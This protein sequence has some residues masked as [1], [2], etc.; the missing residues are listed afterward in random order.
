MNLEVKQLEKKGNLLKLLIKGATPELMNS[1]RRAI[2]LEV[3]TL[4][5]EEVTFFEN[6]SV[7]F[8]EF[9]AHRIG[10]IPIKA[11]L[12][13]YKKNETAKFT[14]DKEGPCTVYGKDIKSADPS[15][16]IIGKKVPLVK[17]NKGQRV[18]MELIATIST[19]K[20]HSKWQ[21]AI[22]GYRNTHTITV[23]KECNACEDCVKHCPKN[24]LEVKAKKIVIT[25]ALKCNACKACVNYC[26]KGH[27]KLETDPENFVFF[28]ESHGQS[29]SEEVALHAIEA[30]KEKVSEFKKSINSLKE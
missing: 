24:I 10:M 26:D 14:L 23:D 20:E 11:D 3:P 19:G 7:M 27:I 29:D 1:F 6:N 28:I 17:L 5:I 30:L 18:K 22:V 16:E 21:P 15:V 8:D 9:L 13:D 12:K 25:D 4:A 2:M